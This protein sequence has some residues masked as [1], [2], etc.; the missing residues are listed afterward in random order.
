MGA[1]SVVA[2]DPTLAMLVSPGRDAN[3]AV[4]RLACATHP[5]PFRAHQFDVVLCN[6][7]LGHVRDLEP[8]LESMDRVLTAGGD[9]VITDFHPEATRRGWQRTFQD[10]NGVTQ[11]I[12]QHLHTLDAYRRTLNRLGLDLQQL[13]EPCWEG[14]PVILGLRA[15][16]PGTSG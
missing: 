14:Q 2:A 4:R 3:D 13:D 5:L 1:A 11:I 15:H 7:V 10:E 12:E 8:A 6:L 16:K 9:L